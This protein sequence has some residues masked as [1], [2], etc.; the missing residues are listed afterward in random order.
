M[1]IKFFILFACL[2]F[3]LQCGVKGPPLPPVETL[4]KAETSKEETQ[5]KKGSNTE[6]IPQNQPKK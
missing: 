1:L 5:K 3:T 4:P 2:V 6:V